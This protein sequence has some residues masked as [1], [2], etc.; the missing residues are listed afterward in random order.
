MQ[1]RTNP[2]NGQP[3]SALGFGCMRFTRRGGQID[4]E[5]ANRELKLAL[6]SGVNYFDTTYIYA[7]SEAA[8]GSFIETYGCRA[9]M[10]IATKLPQYR[11]KK[12]E[13]F[14]AGLRAYEGFRGALGL[15]ERVRFVWTRIFRGLGDFERIP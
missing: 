5:K 4:Q 15:K 11:V 2:K 6:D 8:L 13:D 12:R 3:L 10:N 9:Q 1:Y 14:D 7:G